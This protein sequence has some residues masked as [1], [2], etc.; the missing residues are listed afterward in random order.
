[1]KREDGDDRR[2]VRLTQ[3][4]DRHLKVSKIDIVQSI[5]QNRNNKCK[6]LLVVGELTLETGD[7]VSVSNKQDILGHLISINT[8]KLKFYLVVVVKYFPA[9]DLDDTRLSIQQVEHDFQH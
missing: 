4:A 5:R 3:I 1:M 6:S 9:S 8:M 7:P 2:C